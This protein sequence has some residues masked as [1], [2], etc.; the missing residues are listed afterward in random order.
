MG[1]TGDVHSL[2]EAAVAPVSSSVELSVVLGPRDDDPA[3]ERPAMACRLAPAAQPREVTLAHNGLDARGQE[4]LVVRLESHR[5][6]L[7]R[8]EELGLQESKSQL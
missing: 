3:R 1:E 2:D 8:L 7:V 4:R 5:E 6:A